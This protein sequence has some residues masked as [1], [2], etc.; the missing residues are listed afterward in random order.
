M[1][2]LDK[3]L[4]GPLG[5]THPKDLVMPVLRERVGLAVD[6][7]GVRLVRGSGTQTWVAATV[8]IG[9]P[10]SVTPPSNSRPGRTG[11]WGLRRGTS[12][13]F[14]TPL[15]R[16]RTIVGQPFLKPPMSSPLLRPRAAFG[17][18]PH[19]HAR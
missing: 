12:R 15:R 6:K 16:R 10:C 17:P 18:T 4:P 2:M 11:A 5:L 8:V 14:K 9:G 3:P 7:I 13:R 19:R 1:T